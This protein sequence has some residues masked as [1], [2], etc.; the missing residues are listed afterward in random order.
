MDIK[1]IGREKEQEILTTALKSNEAEMISIIGRRRVGKTFLVNKVY[2]N[3][4]DFEISGIQKAGIDEQLRVFAARLREHFPTAVMVEPPKDWLDAFFILIEYLKQKDQ[5]EKLVVFLDEVPWLATHKSGFLRALSYFWNSWAVKQNIVVV[6][7]GSAAS[8]MIR[9]VLRDKGGLH[10]RVTKR[11]RLN[12]FTLFESEAYLESRNVFLNR[13]QLVQLYMA[14]GGIPHYLKEVKDGLGVVQNINEI[15]FGENG[16]LNDEFLSL[17]PALFNHSDYHFSIIRTLAEKYSGMTRTELLERSGL[18]DGGRITTVLDELAASGFIQSYPI[19]GKRKKGMLYRLIDAYSLF[20]LKFIE[21]NQHDSRDAWNALSQTQTYK[22][23]SGYAFE[24]ICLQHIS[25]IKKGLG[26]IGVYSI[27]SSFYKKGTDAEDGAQ[28]DLVIDRND[29]IINLI[30]AKFY[31]DE[32]SISQEYAKKL[33]R[34]ISVFQKST[35]TK[36]Q[37]FLTLISPFGLKQNKHSLGL[38][39]AD[40]TIDCLFEKV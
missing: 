33:R 23:W 9:K 2:E 30:E 7:C 36:K 26:I 29:Q 20:Y 22:I 11:I 32:I 40:L 31:N 8:W 25:Q 35:K 17:Y 15:C 13:Y 16:L 1:I 34:K 4:I 39:Q 18:P 14:I 21:Q 38:I 5:K 12:P 10:N 28:I 3:R 37:L 6:L 27:S 19:F 24:N